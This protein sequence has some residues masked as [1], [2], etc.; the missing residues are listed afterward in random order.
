MRCR[1]TS[2]SWNPNAALHFVQPN[3]YSDTEP[4]RSKGLLLVHK[5]A[6]RR[7]RAILAEAIV[8]EGTQQA[9]C[10]I[11]VQPNVMITAVKVQR[12]RVIGRTSIFRIASPQTPVICT[13]VFTE[14]KVL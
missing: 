8:A 11:I 14:L 10:E 9:E 13:V 1:P 6:D 5:I 4:K 12:H 2:T 7:T 3:D